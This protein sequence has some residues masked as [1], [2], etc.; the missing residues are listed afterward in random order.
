MGSEEGN[1]SEGHCAGDEGNHSK[2][3]ISDIFLLEI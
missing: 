2:I 3:D 1:Y